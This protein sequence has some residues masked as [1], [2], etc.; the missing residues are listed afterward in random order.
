MIGDSVVNLWL[1]VYSWCA[2]TVFLGSMVATLLR[3]SPL[4]DINIVADMNTSD[5]ASQLGGFQACCARVIV[6]SMVTLL[7]PL[8]CVLYW[9]SLLQADLLTQ[10][11]NS[12]GHFHVQSRN[13]HVQ[14]VTGS[15]VPGSFQHMLCAY[16]HAS[17][18]FACQHSMHY[19]CNCNSKVHVLFGS[20]HKAL[21][22]ACKLN[23]RRETPS[24]CLS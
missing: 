5:P 21:T 3:R 20:S 10:H 2:Y 13:S 18:F 9:G 16:M 4:P 8:S 22:N 12:C 15:R 17:S 23:T 11:D 6:C 19:C 7:M 1:C 14:C 24:E